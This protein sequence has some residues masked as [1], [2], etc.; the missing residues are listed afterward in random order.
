MIKNQSKTISKRI[1][2]LL[3]YE[4]GKFIDNQSNFTSENLI[5]EKTSHVDKLIYYLS[6]PY[7][8]MD[9]C[10]YL[11]EGLSILVSS[12]S[13]SSLIDDEKVKFVF[14]RI[15]SHVEA[16]FHNV[17]RDVDGHDIEI[18]FNHASQD[19]LSLKHDKFDV[20]DVIERL[21]PKVKKYTKIK[22]SFSYEEKLNLL[23]LAFLL[24]QLLHDREVQNILSK[25]KNR[26]QKLK[27]QI[28]AISK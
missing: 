27:E 16:Y 9:L 19:G 26:F 22:D 15:F 6:F 2:E 25:Q 23:R 14:R 24:N 10:E 7:T 17:F 5:K 1:C 4:R 13:G 12:A 18:L 11:A 20:E 3:K 8:N 21:K 28:N